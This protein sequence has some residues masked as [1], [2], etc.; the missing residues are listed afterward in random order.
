MFLLLPAERRESADDFAEVGPDQSHCVG[1]TIAFLP[2]LCR[3]EVV[4]TGSIQQSVAFGLF[5]LRKQ[6][7]QYLRLLFICQ[8]TLMHVDKR[9]WHFT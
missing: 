1:S 2:E 9:W 5:L 6:I 8:Y 7:I 4:L 3:L